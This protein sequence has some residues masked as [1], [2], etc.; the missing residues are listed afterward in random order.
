M[1]QICRCH[2]YIFELLNLKLRLITEAAKEELQ[3]GGLMIKRIAILFIALFV[4]FLVGC[5]YPY[6]SPYI[7][8]DQTDEFTDPKADLIFR[9]MRGNHIYERDPMGLTQFSELNGVAAIHKKSKKIVG[10]S[11]FLKNVRCN[12]RGQSGP[13]YIRDGNEMIIVTDSTRIVLVAR[14]TKSYSKS[15][16][17]MGRVH[18]TYF[19][20]AHYAISKENLKLIAEAKSIKIRVTGSNGIHDYSIVNETF[21]PNISRYYTEE[22]CSRVVL[23]AED[24]DT[25]KLDAAVR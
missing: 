15:E 9:D 12:A 7:V 2:A 4:S 20:L 18:F 21:L 8:N 23:K 6:Q 14:S 25:A 16:I 3:K 22:V 1:N 24:L 19:D 5:A 17:L 13:L 10:I 11:L